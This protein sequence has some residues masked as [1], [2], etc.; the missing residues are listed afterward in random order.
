MPEPMTTVDLAARVAELERRIEILEHGLRSAYT[1]AQVDMPPG[2]DRRRRPA[3]DLDC[4]AMKRP[5]GTALRQNAAELRETWKLGGE[6]LRRTGK[7]PQRPERQAGDALIAL[8]VAGLVAGAW[9]MFEMGYNYSACQ[10]VWIQL[11]SANAQLC[12]TADVAHQCGI[13][14]LIA[15]GVLLCWASCAADLRV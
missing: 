6:K 1:A 3:P 14:M 8:G 13:I 9:L 5:W 10:S 11:N 4:A 2:L 7:P 12:H 15:S